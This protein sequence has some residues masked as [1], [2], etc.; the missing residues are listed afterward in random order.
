MMLYWLVVEDEAK[1]TELS[2]RS[3]TRDPGSLSLKNKILGSSFSGKVHV[4][5][6]S[7]SNPV[8]REF[9]ILLIFI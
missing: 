1:K 4:V 9:N 6:D 3:L 8:I 5:H 2:S 7:Q